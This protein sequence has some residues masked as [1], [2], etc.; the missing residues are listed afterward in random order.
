MIVTEHSLR[1]IVGTILAIDMNPTLSRT[2]SFHWGDKAELERYLKLKK[3]AAY[4]LIWLLPSPDSYSGNGQQV[5]KNCV[6]II[7]TRETRKDMY[8]DERYLNAFA[9][10]LNPLTARLIHGLKVSTISNVDSLD[11]VINKFP[12]YVEADKNYTIDLWDAIQ[13]TISV[14]FNNTSNCLKAI[15]YG[16]L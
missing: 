4:P 9:T 3:G 13:L 15:S 16:E 8:N 10:I 14:R 1:A 6:F 12:N 2:P 7:A 5:D 11:W